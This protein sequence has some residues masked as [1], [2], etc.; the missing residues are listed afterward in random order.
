MSNNKLYAVYAVD[1]TEYERGFGQRPDG[2]SL[3]RSKEEAQACVDDYDKEHNS[4]KV[5]PDCYTRGGEPYL[6]EVEKP[7]YDKVMKSGKVFIS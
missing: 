2:K 3:H 7:L 1:W 6:F 5:V 4:L